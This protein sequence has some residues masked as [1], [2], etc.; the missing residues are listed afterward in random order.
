MCTLEEGFWR[1]TDSESPS[2][3]PIRG[4]DDAALLY[5]KKYCWYHVLVN[6]QYLIVLLIVFLIALAVVVP[7]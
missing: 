2:R 4:M 5:L 6:I 3:N 1:L 7:K